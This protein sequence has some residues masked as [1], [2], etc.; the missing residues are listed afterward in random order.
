MFFRTPF[1][2]TW[3]TAGLL[4]AL[5]VVTVPVVSGQNH[6]D[7]KDFD[8]FVNR[9]I[10]D[11]E[12]PGVA[13]AIVKDDKVVLAKGY[14]VRK[15]GD[16]T[17]VDEKTLF[18]IGS[19]SKAF[20]AA[21]LAM[22]VD[23]K[24]LDWDDHV[25][26]R[27]PGFQLYD[28]WVTKEIRVRDLLCHRS[29]LARG[30]Y[31]WEGTTYTRDEILHR[32]RYL[33]PTWSFRTHFG[34]QNIMFL[35]GGQIVARLS[36]E[37]WD[38]FIKTRIFKPLGMTSS[39]TSVRDLEGQEDVATP[40]L[41]RDGKIVPIQYRNLDNI[42]P[43]GSINSNAVDMAQWVRFQL[44][45]GVFNGQRL[46]SEANM[47]EMHKPQMAIP[48]EPPWSLLIPD[49][50]LISYGFGWFL[51]D[52]RDREVIQHGGN[53]DGMAALAAFMPQEKIGVVVLSN[54][55]SSN[56]REAIMYKA[57]DE[58]LG[59][60]GHEWNSELLAMNRKAQHED[61][62]EWA[63]LEEDRKKDM[64]SALPLERYV[65][66][67]HDDFFGDATVTLDDGKLMLHT[68]AFSCMLS[69][70]S[71]NTFRGEI[72]NITDRV[73]ISFTADGSGKVSEFRIPAADLTM[74]RK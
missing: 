70:W 59:D 24:K 13:V 50:N 36:G 46:I 16:P 29:G 61:D 26:D 8:D 51:H 39:N 35:A 25:P 34:Y 63:K 1:L 19:S 62:A 72:K 44:A 10:R 37:S 17:P 11:W 20:T 43:A 30:D 33:R 18:A 47:D 73:L 65:G 60:S 14:G 54:L 40:H 49:A 68:P 45:N 28:P 55:D 38:D 69:H 2:K 6:P 64:K 71:G 67:Y 12:V 21:S 52:Y 31:V 41:K 57:F 58:Y 56:I 5:M 74:K 23:E 27:L 53:I 66:N 9:A 22:L 42:A 48:V 15:L 32:V 7:F 3:V 4:F